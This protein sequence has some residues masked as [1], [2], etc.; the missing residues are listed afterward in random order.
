MS[1][2]FNHRYIRISSLILAVIVCV[3]ACA[4]L[5][6][7]NRKAKEPIDSSPCYDISV[8]YDKGAKSISVSQ[9]ILYTAPADLNEVVLHIYANAFDKKNNAIDISSVQ[10]NRQN[11]DFEIYGKDRTLLKLPCN[12]RAG[13]LLTLSFKYSVKLSD[14]DTR[15][16]ITERGDANLTC[17]Y[18]VIAKYDG[19]W[20]EDCYAAWG[21]PFFSDISSFYVTVTCDENLTVAAADRR[22]IPAFLTRTASRKSPW[23]SKRKISATSEWLSETLKKSQAPWK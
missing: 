6:A 9:E 4:I 11:S 8:N 5:S 14:T 2:K 17:F 3:S 15:L 19:A 18:P 21:D 1:K 20:R 12:V 16:G 7:C 10:I 13:E 23:K 22:L